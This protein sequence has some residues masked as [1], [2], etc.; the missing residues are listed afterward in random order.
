MQED[1]EGFLYPKVDT[2]LCIN[3]GLCERVCPVLI[4]SEIVTPL[5]VLAAYNNKESV[6]KLS[7]SGG[8]F[9]MLAENIIND[10]GVVFGARFDDN[11]NVIHDYSETIEGLAPFR[12]S[13]YMQSRML[14]NYRKAKKN[15]EEGRKV[16]FSGTPCQIAG[17]NYYLKKQYDNLLCVDCVC[18]GVPST[19]VWNSYLRESELMPS[20]VSF[21]DK[22]NG[23]KRYTVIISG[24]DGKRLS[25]PYTENAY[26]SVF[27][28]SLCLRPSCYDCPAKNG[29]S[30]A[31]ITLGDFWGIDKISPDFDDDNG[32][33]LILV[34]TEKG[35]TAIE[36]LTI[37]KETHKY[38]EVVK[39]NPSIV[40]SSPRPRYRNLFMRTCHKF[41]FHKAH[42]LITSPTVSYKVIRR[43]MLFS[44]K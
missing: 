15:L 13:K 44:C 3:C 22:K 39:Y 31:D 28:S 34:N 42:Q 21:R 16:L 36:K 24:K 8:I 9:T 18:H 26:M 14:V 19:M 29:K 4:Q 33:S 32:C 25:T 35:N 40:S 27:L 11:F 12:G 2:D 17:L 1:Q 20:A 37:S 6:R 5:K 41:G 10:G 30:K 7:S 23:W 43:L 38:D